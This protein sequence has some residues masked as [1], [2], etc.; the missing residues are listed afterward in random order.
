MVIH[1]S[2]GSFTVEYKSDVGSEQA[3][4]MTTAQCL[5]PTTTTTLLKSP[6]P[7]ACMNTCIAEYSSWNW[8]SRQNDNCSATLLTSPGPPL[9]WFCSNW[10][11]ISSSEQ[12][13]TVIGEQLNGKSQKYKKVFCWIQ[14]LELREQTNMTGAHLLNATTTLLTS[15]APTLAPFCSNWAVRGSSK[16]YQAAIGEQLL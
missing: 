11:V 1:S 16:Q 2:T 5:S 13:Q 14:I 12:H 15:P 7:T 9:A 4:K 6:A 8:A 10:G 3:S